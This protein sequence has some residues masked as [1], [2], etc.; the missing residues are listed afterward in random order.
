MR[1]QKCVCIEFRVE[2]LWTVW[3]VLGAFRD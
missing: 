3:S 2:F 1:P